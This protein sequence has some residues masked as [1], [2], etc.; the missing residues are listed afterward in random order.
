MDQNTSNGTIGARRLVWAFLLCSAQMWA[1]P[2]SSGQQ[3]APPGQ[4]APAPDPAPPG[5]EASENDTNSSATQQAPSGTSKDRL[6]FALPNFLTL[7]NVGQ[8]PPLRSGQKFK[9]VAQGAFDPVEFVWF[10]ALS[11][12]SQWENS[13]S[14]Y[15]QG[16]KGYF[17]RY[18]AYAADGWIENFMT[19]AVFASVLHQDPRY[20]QKGKGGFWSRTAYA[21]RCIFITR[22]DNGKTQFNFSEILGSAVSAG[23]STYSYHPRDERNIPNTMSVWGTQVGYDTL[24]AV[25]REFWPDIRRKLKKH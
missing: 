2:S 20:Y 4:T 3:P 24:T 5:Q 25:V 18:G 22:G 21:V 14:G 16:A 10:G 1:Q 23:I 17:K 8:V 15:G 12:I 7:E 19:A 13:E 11:G 6:F 9:A